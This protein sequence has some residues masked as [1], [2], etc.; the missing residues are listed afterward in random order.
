MDIE[1]IDDDDFALS[2]RDRQILAFERQ[3]WRYA[4]AKEQAIRETFGV[5]ATRYYQLLS[6]LIDR[7]QALEHDPMLV[8]RLRRMRAGR[9]RDRATRRFGTGRESGWGHEAPHS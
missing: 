8:K 9:R 3:W 2:D 1:P 6:E 5:S 7:P 4:G